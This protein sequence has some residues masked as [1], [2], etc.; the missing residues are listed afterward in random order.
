M[1]HPDI[2]AHIPNQDFDS[3]VG[4][5]TLSNPEVAVL[6]RETV[7]HVTELGQGSKETT[8]G[9]TSPYQQKM[10]K[11]L[12]K[13]DQAIA[14]N[15]K[16]VKDILRKGAAKTCEVSEVLPNKKRGVDLTESN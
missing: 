5:T 4:D 2:H 13:H 11:R 6:S 8:L 10:W 9:S 7:V 1:P 14:E 3:H 12:V 16:E 15:T